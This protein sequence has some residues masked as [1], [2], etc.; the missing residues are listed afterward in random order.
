M[1]DAELISQFSAH[2]RSALPVPDAQGT[3][4]LHAELLH[5]I[6]LAEGLLEILEWTRQG[7]SADP[8]ACMWLAGLRW[9]RLITGMVPENAPSP[10]HHETESA[11]AALLEDGSLAVQ[12]GTGITSLESLG[13]GEMHYPSAPAQPEATDDEALLRLTPIALVPYVEEPMRVRW[14]EQNLALTHGHPDLLRQGQLLV[15]RIHQ[16]A[17]SGKGATVPDETGIEGT[18]GNARSPDQQ[19]HPLFTVIT[20]LTERWYRVTDPR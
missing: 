5:R 10:P 12:P 16:Q 19:D 9:H 4:Q 18:D 6:C 14:V 1:D 13:S 8:L 17:S 11:L 20:D 2:M 15:A 3:M 7:M